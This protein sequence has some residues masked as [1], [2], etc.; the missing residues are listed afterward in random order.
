M[1]QFLSGVSPW[2]PEGDMEDPE[3][4]GE[5]GPG[6]AAKSLASGVPGPIFFLIKEQA[7]SLLAIKE[8]QDRVQALEGFRNDIFFAIQDIQQTMQSTPG[9]SPQIRPLSSSEPAK[10]AVAS[11][12]D[13][14]A[15]PGVSTSKSWTQNPKPRRHKEALMTAACGRTKGKSSGS[16]SDL[17]P[18]VV[19]KPLVASLSSTVKGES[20]SAVLDSDKQ[21]SGLD[22]DCRDH[23]SRES[24]LA[25]KDE[26]LTL[27]DIIDE[28]G[29]QLQQRVREMEKGWDAALRGG[30][31]GGS[32][33]SEVLEFHEKELQS[34]LSEMEVERSK[35]RTMVRQ[36]QA[37]IHRMEGE[38]IACEEKLQASITEKEELEKKVH[39]LH[40]QYVRGGGPR[41]LPINASTDPWPAG[42]S[43]HSLGAQKVAGDTDPGIATEESKAKVSSIL[44]ESNLL[45]L[46]KVLLLYT[47]E[48]QALRKKLEEGNRQWFGK[49]SEWKATEASLRSDIQ[50]LIQEREVCL[51][52]LG[53]HQRDMRLLQ[54][55][56]KELELTVWALDNDEHQGSFRRDEDE[57]AG[58][59]PVLRSP[60]IKFPRLYQSDI[61]YRDSCS[62]TQSLPPSILTQAKNSPLLPRRGVYG[63]HF[64]RSSL[65]ENS[66][67]EAGFSNEDMAYELVDPRPPKAASAFAEPPLPPAQK[68]FVS[69]WQDRR[70]GAAVMPSDTVRL[71]NL[72][73]EHAEELK[74]GPQSNIEMI[75]NEFDPLS[76]SERQSA[77]KPLDFEDSLDL[78]IPLKPMRSASL[79]AAM[80]GRSG[81][82]LNY[83]PKPS[84][85]SKIPLDQKHRTLGKTQ[86]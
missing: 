25:P 75:C 18:G 69:Y 80:V 23:G 85:A 12:S 65:A 57:L 61:S 73:D 43:L 60:S 83:F 1:V 19:A 51:D 16:G 74:S 29:L 62:K 81:L 63:A 72:E 10:S 49:L 31:V 67:E 79:T 52:A 41:S 86:I 66:M 32:S 24:T 5:S 46:K 40:M 34:R 14:R 28:R 84:G 30:A 20:T 82:K 22:S 78:S 3:D 71:M 2:H 17:S 45:E 64:K 33:S 6:S 13:S 7:K 42:P 38:R 56:Y 9:R 68:A 47:L 4:A 76:D 58:G 77:S 26:L 39:S 70:L 50:N 8:L 53:R 54:A 21:D 48:N 11:R 35:H 27:L 36:L 59:S 44:K 15:L 55:K 37:T